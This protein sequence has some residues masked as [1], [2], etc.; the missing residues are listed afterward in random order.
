VLVGFLQSAHLAARPALRLTHPCPTARLRQGRHPEAAEEEALCTGISLGMTLI[1]TA[2]IYGNGN[3]SPLGGPDSSLL[4]NPTLAP[5]HSA[6]RQPLLL[7]PG[8][9]AAGRSLPFPNPARWRT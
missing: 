2:E 8:P 5:L 4:R 6:A 7:W 3:A 1:D 9:S